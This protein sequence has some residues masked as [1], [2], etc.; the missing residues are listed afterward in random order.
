MVALSL[1]EAWGVWLPPTSRTAEDALKGAVG[2]W[3]FWLSG[4]DGDIKARIVQLVQPIKRNMASGAGAMADSR[5]QIMRA[6]T[7]V[8]KWQ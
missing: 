1:H 2:W 8:E 4:R 6:R 5:S 7:A 3:S